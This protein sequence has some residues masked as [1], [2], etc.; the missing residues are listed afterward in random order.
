MA[1]PAVWFEATGIAGGAADWTIA[2]VPF[3]R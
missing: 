1:A 3:A 2:I